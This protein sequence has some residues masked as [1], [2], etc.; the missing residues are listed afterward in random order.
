MEI[1]KEYNIKM[2]GGSLKGLCIYVAGSEGQFMLKQFALEVCKD[3]I[4]QYKEQGGE[5][6]QK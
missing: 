2:D 1:K 3:M 5:K 6:D 4:S